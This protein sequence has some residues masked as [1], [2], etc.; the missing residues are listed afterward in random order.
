M[1]QRYDIFISSGVR[2]F[3]DLRALLPDLRPHGALH[4]CSSFLDEKQLA[5]LA[6]LVDHVHQPRHS[7]DPYSNFNLFNI[8]DLARLARAP[9]F[10]KLDTDMRLRPGWISYVDECLSDRPDAVLFGTHAGTN[11]VDYDIS[12]PL[13]RRRLGAD[14]RVKNGLK[15]NGSFYVCNTSFFREHDLTLQLLHDFVYAF[16]N[17]RRVR[18]SHLQEDGIETDLPPEDLVRLRGR[19]SLRQGQAIEDTIRSLAVHQL[20]AADRMFVRHA[21]GRMSLPDKVRAP[22]ALRQL[23]KWLLDRAQVPWAA[24]ERPDSPPILPSRSRPASH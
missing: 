20:G 5:A 12:G 14:V 11:R 23:H 22:S 1:S 9:H 24:S 18:A 10:I 21:G 8:R 3:E 13:V 6:P 7:D 19:C 4:V 2:Q 17:G 15:I 16:E